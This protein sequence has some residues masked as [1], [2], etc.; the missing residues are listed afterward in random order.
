MLSLKLEARQLPSLTEL[1]LE[2]VSLVT[3]QTTEE[4]V[5]EWGGFLSEYNKDPR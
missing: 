3:G 4:R 2:L 5:S 1:A